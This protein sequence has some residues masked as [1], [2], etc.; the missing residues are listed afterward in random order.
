MEGNDEERIVPDQSDPITLSKHLSRYKFALKY[1]RNKKVLDAACGVGYG[2]SFLAKHG[3]KEVVGVDISKDAILYAD[4]KF[5][6]LNTRFMRMNGTD[7][8]FKSNSFD[9]V[10]SFETIEH[11]ANYKKFLSEVSRVLKGTGVLIMSTPNKDKYGIKHPFHVKEF[12]KDEFEALLSSYFKTVDLFGQAFK[13]K[14]RYIQLFIQLFRLLPKGVQSYIKPKLASKS[15]TKENDY[16]SIS[17]VNIKYA[18]HMV[19]VCRGKHE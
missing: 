11:I 15:Q 2:S 12:R 14:Y 9:V 3:A 13:P 19:A 17:K 1:V 16:F 6:S 4:S 10:C 8:K 18:S 7:L 5:D